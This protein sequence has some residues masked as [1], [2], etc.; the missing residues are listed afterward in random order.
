[1]LYYV[2]LNPETI[3]SL[4]IIDE[5]EYNQNFDTIVKIYSGTEK[6]CHD[7]ASRYDGSISEY[8]EQIHEC[9]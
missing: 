5:E 7:F 3:V 1:M 9:L 6:E 4:K 2:I 8:I